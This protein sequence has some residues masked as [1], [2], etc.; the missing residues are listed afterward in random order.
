MSGERLQD[1][2]S[3]G[4]TP[5]ISSH[6]GQSCQALCHSF[7]E[8]DISMLLGRVVIS[9]YAHQKLFSVFLCKTMLGVQIRINLINEIL[10]G[11]ITTT[12]IFIS[13]S[14]KRY[15]N[16][17]MQ[18]IAAIF[19]GCKNDNFWLHFFDYFHIFAQNIDCGY[20]LEPPH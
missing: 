20:T 17:A 13:G 12:Y 1:H 15:E 10:M 6:R 11:T 8:F 2:W 4:F 14:Q 18:H 9:W 7:Q 3:S 19:H 16:M 5:R